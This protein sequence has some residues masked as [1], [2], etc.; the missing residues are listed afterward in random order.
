M[1]ALEGVR[2]IDQTQVMAG[3]FCSMLLADMGAEVIKVEPPGGEHTRRMELEIIPG[4]SA[5]FL[6]VNRNKKGM[7][8]DLKRPEGVAILKRLVGTADVLV[9]NYRPGVA[10]RLGVDYRALSAVRPRLIYCSIS[11]FGQTGPYASR[12]GFDLV[13][14]GMSG[15]MSAT[16]SEGGP[17]VKVGVPITDLGAGLFAVFGILCAL[18]A[19][20]VTGRGQ[21][22]DTSL[23][24]AGLAMSAWEATEYWYTGEIPR[25]LG[26]AHRLNAP[27][28]AYRASDGHFTVGAANQKLWPLFAGIL[29]LD[30]LI[31]DPRFR[32][33]G[34]RLRNRAELEVLVEQVTVREPRVHW[35]ARCEEAGIPAGPIYTVPEA[36]ADPHAQARGMV[37][38]YDHP[39]VGRVKGLG[40]PVKLSRSPAAVQKAAPRVGEDNDAILGELGYDAAAIAGFRDQGV[41]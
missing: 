15:I 40:N 8:L 10:S 7:T 18:R 34:A 31:D 6:A 21:L 36:L 35:L 2:V 11:G 26:T 24:E 38:E 3:P 27:Y 12:G 17:P 13:A 37:Q 23:F 30:H 22:V 41:I 1:M 19:R 29:G 16:G 14:Q 20:R 28:Q 33:V 9:E 25:R 5:S 39:Q 4:V 32:D